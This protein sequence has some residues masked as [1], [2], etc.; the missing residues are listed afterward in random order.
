[1]KG[2]HR[3][4]NRWVKIGEGTEDWPDVCK[5][6]REIRYSGWATAEVGGGKRDRLEDIKARMDRVFAM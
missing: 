1:M 3:P 2:Y 5:A 6:L 4:R